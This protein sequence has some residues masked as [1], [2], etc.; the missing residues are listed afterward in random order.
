M[1]GHVRDNFTQETKEKIAH[2]VGYRCSKPDC[3]IPTRG[4]ASDPDGTINV[5]FAAHITAASP[6]GKRYDPT[7]TSEQRKH[8][9]NG[10]WLC[11]THA[12]LID[13]DESHF[14]VEELVRWKRLAEQRSFLS[15]VSSSPNS[16]GP[17]LADDQDMQTVFNLLLDYAKSDLS[18][19]QNMP[20]WPPHAIS[21][22]LRMV[23]EKH[24][25]MFTASGLVSGLDVF[26]EVAVIAPPGTGKTTTLLQ[27]VEAILE[28]ASFI[29]VFVPLNEWSTRT[30]A[31]F[32][33][34]VRRAAFRDATESQF[35]RLALHGRLVLIL[36]G[37]NELD[38]TSKRRVRTDIRLLRRD[39]PDIRLVVSSRYNNSEIPLNGPVVEV[40]LLTEEQQLEIAKALHG[41]EGESLMDHA[42]RT[43][44]LRDLVAIPLYL[45]ALL[46]QAPGGSLPTTKEEVLKS[47]VAELEQDLDKQATMRETLQGLHRE[48]LEALAVEATRQ[49]MGALSDAQ[50]RAIVH[51]VQEQFIAGRQ[52]AQ[53]LEPMYILDALASAHMLVRS[54]EN[55]GGVAFQHQQFQ[56][57]FAS[58]HVQKMM[59]AVASGDNNARKA[60]REN[61]LDIPVWEEAI[62]F[63]CD[64]LSRTDQ[65]GVQ[66]TACTILE[67]LGIDPLL[68]AEMIWRA[69]DRAWDA[70]SGDVLSFAER[71]H[72]EGRIDRAV[73]FMIAAGRSEFSKYVWPL[74]SDPDDQVHLRALRAGY[75]FRPS[76]IGQDVGERIGALPEKARRHVVSEIA[77]NGDMDGIELA[78]EIA[79]NDQSA[80]VKNAVI[81]ALVFRRADRIATEILKTANDDVWRNIAQKWHPHEFADPEVSARMERENAQLQVEK[82]D[83]WQV[84]NTLV[85]TNGHGPDAGR[86]IRELVAHVDFSEKSQSTDW[87][88]HRAYELY[89]N[90]V[91][92]GLISQ[93]ENNKPVP[94][95]TE[96]MLLASDLIIDDAPLA[97]RVFHPSGEVRRADTIVGVI[98]PKAAGKLIDQIYEIHAKLKTNNEKYDKALSDEYYRLLDCISGTK[99][100]VFITSVLERADTEEP[101]EI[102]VLAD[103]L[104]RHG[105]SVEREP[106]KLDATTHGKIT[107]AVQRWA[108]I[109]LASPEA[110][111]AQ[112]AKIAQAAERLGSPALVPVLQKLLTE[113][114]VRRKLAQ[115]EFQNARTQGLQIQNDAHMSWR[116]QYT[117]AFAAIG[118]GQTVQLM[119]GYLPDREFGIDAAHVIRS[120][121]RKSQPAEDEG[122]FLKSWPDFSVVPSEYAQRQSGTGPETHTFVNDMLAVVKQLIEQGGE[123][124]GYKHAL[125]LAAVAF[126]MPYIDKTDTIAKLLRLPVPPIEKQKLLTVLVLSGETIPSDLVL[127]GVNDLLEQAKTNPWMLQEQNG[128]RLNHWLRLFPFTESPSSTM[129]VLDRLENCHLENLCGLLSALAYAPL[130]EAEITLG[131]LANRYEPVLNEYEWLAALSKR[132]TPSAAK[133]LLDLACNGSLPSKRGE[134]DRFHLGRELSTFMTSHKE[135]RREVYRRFQGLQDPAI[136]AVLEYAIADTADSDGVLLLTREA[137]TTEKRFQDTAL[138]TALRNVL[139]HLTPI[140]SS[141][142]Q[143]LHSLPAP[144]LRKDLCKLMIN[145]TAAESRL[146]AE[147]LNAVDEIRDDYGHVDTEPR[148]P[149]I[150]SGIP[151]PKIGR[152][153]SL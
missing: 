149:D 121:W 19:F 59:L 148:H 64:R 1:P 146:A 97:D 137:A 134:I 132:G 118:D 28:N 102:A 32:Q 109:L 34:L 15:V 55:L 71:W 60:L 88:V 85:N 83:P 6:G 126:S 10:I 62:L 92:G 151:W 108:E 82:T 99:S 49:E 58:F 74:I 94:F 145:G 14:T 77:S 40:E 122:G 61:V 79:K 142:V 51:A 21:L 111:R 63:A 67:T 37:W 120:V 131:E 46:Q 12:K 125:N 57:W 7:L 38:K 47:F 33:S 86:K 75:R 42:W 136:K 22:N 54:G 43:P 30:D 50:A 139:V 98:G 130:D 133:I 129:Q 95:G 2:R 116:L 84:L 153:P 66:A 25:K 36:D 44:G 18:A 135:F 78:A 27:L 56:E 89:P 124:A 140:G 72:T 35:E 69:S 113:E 24:T 29:A 76:V 80:K 106:L 53:A 93:L 101:E 3:G 150:A 70:I 144:A 143:Q 123:A 107:T 26:D 103:L 11:G 128:W 41:S 114:L 73:S 39:F 117:R 65:D 147:C 17:I 141:G 110:T 81:D 8:H 52:I 138:Y 45:T 20:G 112:F 96:K 91:V 9:S 4:A 68:S 152:G 100:N 16:V 31:F 90:D 48:Y 87:L 127:Q 13:S 23:D 5:G 104:S 115:Q 119:K 105:G